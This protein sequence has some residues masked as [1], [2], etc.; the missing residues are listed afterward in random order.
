MGVGADS[1]AGTGT[2]AGASFVIGGSVVGIGEGVKLGG[3]AVT[4]G[5]GAEIEE[6]SSALVEA[7]RQGANELRVPRTRQENESLK[8]FMKKRDP[9]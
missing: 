3:S 6:A 8:R 7:T 2:G 9:I 1:G 5:G 4:I